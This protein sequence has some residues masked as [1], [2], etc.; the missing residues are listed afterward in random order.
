MCNK[1]ITTKKI[2]CI[3][4]PCNWFSKYIL[5]NRGR[6]GPD[7]YLL[8]L[9]S[10]FPPE[11]C[12]S[13][14]RSPSQSWS[15]THSHFH[16]WAWNDRVMDVAVTVL[17]WGNVFSGWPWKPPCHRFSRGSEVWQMWTK[18]GLQGPRAGTGLV[19]HLWGIFKD[20][21]ALKEFTMS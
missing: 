14:P 15:M 6:R 13:E 18:G 2:L 3:L 17:R 10:M 9:P 7:L 5:Q 19:I 20:C 16:R 12:G 4:L 8:P 11:C 1:Q 21:L